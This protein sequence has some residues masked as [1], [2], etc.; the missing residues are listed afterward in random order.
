MFRIGETPKLSATFL[1]SAGELLNPA[2]VTLK[3]RMPD[4]VE[5][6]VVPTST[7]IGAYAFQMGALVLPG[8]Y[9]YRWIGTSGVTTAVVEGVFICSKSGFSAP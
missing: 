7:G 5:T 9:R 2:T 4:G 8:E 1:D 6:L 3:L